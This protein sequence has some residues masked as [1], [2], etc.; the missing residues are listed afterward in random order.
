MFKKTKNPISPLRK[1]SYPFSARMPKITGDIF[2]N[3]KYARINSFN[4][5]SDNFIHEHD[6]LHILFA[7]CSNTFGDGLEEDEIWAKRLYKK[8]AEKTKVSGF[9]NIG[10]PGHG[11]MAIINDIFKYSYSVAKPDVIFV[12][13][14]TSRRFYWHNSKNNTLIYHNLNE[15]EDETIEIWNT[16]PLIEYQY[17]FMLEQFCKVGNIKL[18]YGTWDRNSHFSMYKDLHCFIDINDDE[19]ITKYIND[20]P[21]DELAMYARDGVH[22]GLAYHHTW[23]EMMYNRYTEILI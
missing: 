18:I 2:I 1:I 22:Y 5:R 20:N 19:F 13:F 23:A 9:F 16:I 7:G 11:I 15:P 10:T 3:E 8:I 6:G 14:P 4:Y 21:D 17:L 12:N